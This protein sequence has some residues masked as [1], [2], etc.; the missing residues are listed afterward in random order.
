MQKESEEEEDIVLEAFIDEDEK[1]KKEDAE[2]ISQ[3]K[4]ISFGLDHSLLVDCQSRIYSTG[5]NRYGRLGHGDEKDC[6]KFT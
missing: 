6:L 2:Y 1:H 5:F 4:K 3:F